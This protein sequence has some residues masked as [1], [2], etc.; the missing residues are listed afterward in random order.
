VKNTEHEN[1]HRQY[2]KHLYRGRGFTL[3]EILIAIF[4]LALVLSTVYAAYT[5]TYRVIRD[6]ESDAEIYHLARNTVE[7]M[8]RDFGSICSFQGSFFFVSRRSDVIERDLTEISFRSA[9]HIPFHP[10]DIPAGIALIVYRFE[11]GAEKQGYLLLRSDSLYDGLATQET[12]K[13]ISKEKR[14]GYVLCERLHSLSFKFT[15][16]KGKEYDAWD[17]ASDNQEQKGKA[18]SIVTVELKLINPGN[19]EK[20]FAFKTRIFLPVSE[21]TLE[22]NP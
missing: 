4:I 20:P 6:H 8:I 3:I 5:G 10:K 18:P 1:R 16:K 12:S 14:G 7:G 21:V 17:S 13:E 19:P 2:R 22:K 15:D 11:E 9:N